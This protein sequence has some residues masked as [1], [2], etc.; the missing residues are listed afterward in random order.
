MPSR[1]EFLVASSLALVSP[2]AAAEEPG[3]KFLDLSLL[4]ADDYPCTWPAGFPPFHEKCEAGSP[5]T[6]NG[7]P[8]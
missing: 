8:P 4:V 5:W 3:P 2:A 1:R 6:R 7:S